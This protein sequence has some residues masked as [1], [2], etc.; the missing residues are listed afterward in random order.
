MEWRRGPGRGGAFFKIP[1]SWVL[2]VRSSRGE[3][4]TDWLFETVSAAAR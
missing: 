4:E 1:L 3:E 2:A